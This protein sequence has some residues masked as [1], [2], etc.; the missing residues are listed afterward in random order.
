VSIV[1]SRNPVRGGHDPE[2]GKII[3]EKILYILGFALF[4]VTNIIIII[5]VIS[6]TSASFLYTF[7][8][9]RHADCSVHL[10]K[11]L[12]VRGIG[13]CLQFPDRAGIVIID[14]VSDL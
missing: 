5:I 9:I 13:V 1:L 12:T 7:V 2:S 3:I 8:T 6:I 14:L 4:I 11:L 10:E